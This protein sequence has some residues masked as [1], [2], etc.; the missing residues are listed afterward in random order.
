VIPIFQPGRIRTV[1]QT[2][3]LRSFA[4]RL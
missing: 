3:R 2:V 1:L 4:E